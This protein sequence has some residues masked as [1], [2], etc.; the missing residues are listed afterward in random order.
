MLNTD[1]LKHLPDELK[2]RLV[3]FEETFSTDGWAYVQEWAQK[4][5]DECKDRMLFCQ[6]WDQ[7]TNLQ[8]RWFAYTELANLEEATYKEFEGLA[9]Q[10]A[11]HE[12]EE[13]ELEFE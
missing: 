12:I 11:E 7:Y 4:T 3:K 6:T 8:G 5:A 13:V 9:M 1:V 10:A 2:A